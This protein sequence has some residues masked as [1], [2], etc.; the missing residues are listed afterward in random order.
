M[1]TEAVVAVIGVLFG[2]GTIAAVV[3]GIVSHKKGV[4]DA[5]VAKD[6]TAIQGFKDLAES[7]RTEVDRLKAAREADSARIDRIEVQIAVERDLKWT[8]I[9]HIR[10]L[11]SWITQNITGVDPPAVPDEL[12]PHI[13]VPRKDKE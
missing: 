3:Q 10:S 2:G 12:A 13:I 5:D 4:R 11:Y 7:L 1:S 9:Q 8:A 6:Q